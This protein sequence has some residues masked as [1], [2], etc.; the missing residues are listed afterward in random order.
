MNNLSDQAQVACQDIMDV[1]GSRT[2]WNINF[3][4]HS[5]RPIQVSTSIIMFEGMFMHSTKGE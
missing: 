2:A 4:S 3:V 5:G 1:G